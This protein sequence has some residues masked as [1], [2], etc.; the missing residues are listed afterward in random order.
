MSMNVPAF[1]RCKEIEEVFVMLSGED[2]KRKKVLV[3]NDMLIDWVGEKKKVNENGTSK[4][5][6]P[7]TLNGMVR[8]FFAV[9][10]DQFNW[11][12]SP[13]DFKFDGGYNGFLRPYVKSD[14]LKM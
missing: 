11:T 13:N 8:S 12:Y 9:T 6:S 14:R 2:E 3:L 10:K 7:G 5:P 1:F 4:Y